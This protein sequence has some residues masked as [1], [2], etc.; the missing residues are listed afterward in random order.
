MMRAEKREELSIFDGRRRR[1]GKGEATL[2]GDLG[3][4][5]RRTQALQD[6][7]GTGEIPPTAKPRILLVTGHDP[8]ITSCTPEKPH[9]IEVKPTGP[10]SVVWGPFDETL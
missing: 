1:M 7:R 3:R 9:V 5:S 8:L 10:S 4:Q 6:P 2:G